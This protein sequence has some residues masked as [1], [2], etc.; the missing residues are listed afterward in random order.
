LSD[1][2]PKERDERLIMVLIVRD[3]RDILEANLRYHHAVGVDRF[4]VTDNGSTDETPEILARFAKAGLVHVIDEP[5]DNYYEQERNWLTRMARIAATELQADWVLYG[6]A[7]EFWL[8]AEGS[9]RDVLASIPKRYGAVVAPRTEFVGRPDGPGTFA[10][11]LTVREARSRAR[12]KLAHRPAQDLVAIDRG[13]HA[14]AVA[15]PTGAP[16]WP[17]RI[18]HFPVRSFAQFEQRAKIAASPAYP[19]WGRFER[20]RQQY[21]DGRLGELYAELVLDDEQ[22]EEGI[23]SGRL[24]RDQRLR[25][26]VRVCPD[27][28]T[29]TGPGTVRA[30]PSPEELARELSDLEF[31]AMQLL[32]R[33]Q[34]W[35]VLQRNRNRDELSELSKK[36]HRRNKRLVEQRDNARRKK[37]RLRRLLKEQQARSRTLREALR[38]ER[39]RPWSRARRAVR[40]AFR[41]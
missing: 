26:L 32:G 13:G 23:R 18:L 40:R 22:V 29:G 7:D 28:L 16:E 1:D 5:E 41:R 9:L 33:T 3:E 34:G 15:G 24:V 4:V 38:A 35:L 30:T 17:V 12:P 14:V 11:R 10:E 36:L 31:D 20:L 27:P 6:D 2:Q 37:V 8:P 25:D 39:S 21:E 19:G